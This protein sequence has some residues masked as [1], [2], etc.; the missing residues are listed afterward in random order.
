MC[1]A[2]ND[3]MQKFMVVKAMSSTFRWKEKSTEHWNITS[4]AQKIRLLRWKMKMRTM[5]SVVW[6]KWIAGEHL[7][8]EKGSLSLT[9]AADSVWKELLFDQRDYVM[10]RWDCC[11]VNADL[12]T[13]KKC[14]QCCQD[15]PGWGT[16]LPRQVRWQEFKK[17]TVSYLIILRNN[18]FWYDLG[19]L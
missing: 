8:E 12:L 1:W 11:Y 17:T 10:L 15:T 19:T 2:T 4:D 18:R 5:T 13:N 3:E 7:A 6:W 14:R 9:D 16:T